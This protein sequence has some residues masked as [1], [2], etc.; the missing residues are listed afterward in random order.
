MFNGFIDLTN[1][2]QNDWGEQLLKIVVSQG[3]GDLF[4]HSQSVEVLVE[5]QP[6]SKLLQGEIDR[7]K[8]KGKGLV[9]RRDFPVEELSFETDS[10]LL[11]FE[12]VLKGKIHLK[13]PTHAIAQVIISQADIN[14]A[15]QAELVQKQMQ[16]LIH[17]QPISFGDIQVQILP[18]NRLHF[19]AKA[20]VPNY[21]KLPICVT[22]NIIVDRPCRLTLINPQFL[23]NLVPEYLTKMVQNL[24]IIFAE[25]LNNLVNVE[26]FGLDGV[27]LLLNQVETQTEK[28]IFSGDAEITHFPETG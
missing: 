17:S 9:I 24:N 7:L 28:L 1:S 23:T 14:R 12:S 8:I 5:S 6:A 26:N 22:G 10:V 25:S 11:N 21:G 13:Q 2:L 18:E 19:F 20:D 16:Q 15:F 4:T 3:I 27:S